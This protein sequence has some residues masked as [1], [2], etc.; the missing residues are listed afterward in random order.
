[1]CHG[2]TP[3]TVPWPDRFDLLEPGT[4]LARAARLVREFHDAVAG[5]V[6][7]PGARWQVL[8]VADLRRP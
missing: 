3:G 8:R 5:F 6:P 2:V 7:P 1:L 4:R